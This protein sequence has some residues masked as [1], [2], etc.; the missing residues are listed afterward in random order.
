MKR[1]KSVTIAL[2]EASYLRIRVFVAPRGMSLSSAIGFLLENLPA[3]SRA[4]GK[5]HEE[6]QALATGQTVSSS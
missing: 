6:D 4:L 2:S 3:I 1:T 5:I